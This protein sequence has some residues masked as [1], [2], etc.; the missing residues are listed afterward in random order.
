MY[1]SGVQNLPSGFQLR[2]ARSLIGWSQTELAKQTGIN[3]ATIVRMEAAGHEPVP[4]QSRNLQHI[5]NVL[6]DAGV[7]FIEE[8]VVLVKKAKK[9]TQKKIQRHRE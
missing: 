1:V 9:P 7:E 3:P 4:G 5:I 2:A 8:G 6:R